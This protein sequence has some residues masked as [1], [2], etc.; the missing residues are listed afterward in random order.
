MTTTPDQIGTLGRSLT[1]TTKVLTDWVA[2]AT[3]DQLDS[4]ATLMRAE[5]ASRQ[6]WHRA[7]LLKRARLPQQKSL[8]GYGC[9]TVALP[10]RADAGPDHRAG[11][12]RGSRGPHLHR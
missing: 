5:V 11:V 2:G 7:R 1:L 12:H 8:E 3:G 4:L 9:Q 10:P 6:A